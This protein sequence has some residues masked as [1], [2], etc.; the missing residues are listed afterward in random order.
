MNRL[1][2]LLT[3]VCAIALTACAKTDTGNNAVAMVTTE[4]NAAAAINVQDGGTPVTAAA[5]TVPGFD[6]ARVP[7]VNPTLGAFPYFGILDGYKPATKS[8][9][10]SWVGG[11]LRDANFDGYEVFDGY[12]LI[13]IEGRLR[14]VQAI[15]TGRSILEAMRNYKALVENAGGVTVYEGTGQKMLD[16]KLNYTDPRHRNRYTM[17]GN[18]RQ[19]VYMLRTPTREIWVE[20]YQMY[21]DRADNY[22]LTVVEK[23][24]LDLSAKLMP[25]EAMKQALDAT[26]RVALYVNFDTD[27]TAINADSQPLLGEIVKLLKDDPKLM[28][29]VEGHTDDAGTPVYNQ[30]LSEGRAQS[31]VRALVEAGIDTS[32]LTSKGFGQTRPLAGNE[33]DSGRAKNRRVELVKR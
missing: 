1:S 4:R 11:N 8:D 5:P 32:R 13:A 20:V 17:G 18:E 6:S 26:G 7:V 25:A 12:K 14:T 28:L 29:T 27:K 19:G 15:G 24:A 21:G 23:K 16:A 9:V 33:S 30:K 3:T 10:D 2:L 22:W 31:V